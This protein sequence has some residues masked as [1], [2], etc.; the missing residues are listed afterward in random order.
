MGSLLFFVAQPYW[1]AWV[2]IGGGLVVCAVATLAPL[3]H[4]KRVEYEV[5]SRPVATTTTEIAILDPLDAAGKQEEQP[6]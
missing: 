5:Q 1:W 6:A 4:R 3:S 2:F